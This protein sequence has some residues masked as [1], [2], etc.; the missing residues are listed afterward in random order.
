MNPPLTDEKNILDATL[1][2]NVGV[3]TK[4]KY[5]HRTLKQQKINKNYTTKS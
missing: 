1:K 5:N 4:T 3:L 2:Y